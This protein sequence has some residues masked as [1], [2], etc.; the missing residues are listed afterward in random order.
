MVAYLALSPLA[1]VAA[2]ETDAVR[3]AVFDFE[4][5]DTSIEGETRGEDPA[6]AL[7]LEMMGE[8]LRRFFQAAPGIELADTGG[9]REGAAGPELHACNGCAGKLAAEA[10]ADLAVTGTVQKV[11]NLILNINVYVEDVASGKLVQA[12]SADIRGNTDQSWLRGLQ[13][14]IKNRLANFAA[15][16]DA[17]RE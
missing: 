5:I 13:W 7:R 10:G 17:D 16:T 11:S 9:L 6:E 1:G 3:V 14:L 4:L 2:E 15:A 8:Q 12:A